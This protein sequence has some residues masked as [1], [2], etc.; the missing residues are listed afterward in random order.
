MGIQKEDQEGTSAERR[1]RE[2]PEG[3][4]APSR[5]ERQDMSHLSIVDTALPHI[6]AKMQMM[7]ERMDFMINALKGRV[8][9]DL[10]DLVH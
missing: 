5:L 4:N 3:S 2:G 7:R 8:S 6:V 1:D 9:S 10:N